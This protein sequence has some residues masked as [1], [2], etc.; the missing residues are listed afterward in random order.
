MI[1]IEKSGIM[2]R[3]KAQLKFVTD[4][5]ETLVHP[6]QERKTPV[7]I[8]MMGV[9]ECA[10]EALSLRMELRKIRIPD[11]T[12]LIT[13]SDEDYDL[14]SRVHNRVLDPECITDICGNTFVEEAD[15]DANF[16]F[17]DST[18]YVKDDLFYANSY[19]YENVPQFGAYEILFF[20]N[21]IPFFTKDHDI[22]W[23]LYTLLKKVRKGGYLFLGGYD[24]IR[25][26]TL[27][28]MM[29]RG[30]LV[31]CMEKAA[32]IHDGWADRRSGHPKIKST[33]FH[34][35]EYVADPVYCSV[36]RRT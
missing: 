1:T 20:Q 13:A 14:I 10:C 27:S 19:V 26:K 33:P 21:I 18:W 17:E 12:V 5:I 15:L 24:K 31:P 4:L 35:G 28:E 16:I 36:F 32:E 29:S 25:E 9:G 2:Y 34:L 3:N 22:S 11:E 8:G 7:S 23:I 30:L 6:S